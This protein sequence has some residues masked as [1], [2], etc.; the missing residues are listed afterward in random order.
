MIN[1]LFVY[2][3]LEIDN[4]YV[5][6]LVEI[7]SSIDN[8]NITNSLDEFWKPSK[9]YNL[10]IINWPEYLFKWRRDINEY[11]VQELEKQIKFYKDNSSKIMSIVH[12]EYAHH[13]R[14]PYRDQIF[15]ICYGQSNILA[16]LG[17][18][19]KTYYEEKYK[20]R[21]I[22]HFLLYHPLYKE[23]SLN[24]DPKEAK[25]HIGISQNKNI[26]FVPGSVRDEFEYNLILKTFKQIQL[27]NKILLIQKFDKEI[28]PKR[29]SIQHFL[30]KLNK[31]YLKFF[32]GIIIGPKK[33]ITPFQLSNYFAA[34]NI[35]LLS[36][37][38]ILNSGNVY[39]ANQFN[40][41][42]IG[43]ET[44]N[45]TEW[46]RYCG[47]V[48]LDKNNSNIIKIEDLNIKSPKNKFI[49]LHSDKNIKEQFVK[50]IAS[51]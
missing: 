12:D 5:K 25:K 21:D 49:E 30:L 39:L 7:I 41:K 42:I 24:L 13:T 6:R 1:I 4:E 45:I 46:L 33:H 18:F 31:L 26:V 43:F 20:N 8:I 11:D 28:I 36:R 44:G 23:F 34:S 40:K 32:N 16:H 10:I 3:L 14:T 22:Q 50:I 47:D 15:D 17:T 29:F 9:H 48:V 27:K 38:K 2:K 37:Y 51:L 35:I 19:S